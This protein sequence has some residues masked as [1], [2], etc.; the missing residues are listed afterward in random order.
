MTDLATK[1]QEGPGSRELD[2]AFGAVF[3]WRYHEERLVS[4]CWWGLED[5]DGTPVFGGWKPGNWSP[6]Q[7]ESDML[8]LARAVPGIIYITVHELISMTSIVTL[9]CGLFID[10]STWVTHEGIA[11]EA[12]CAGCIA[13]LRAKEAEK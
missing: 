12:T 9:S 8:T 10:Q 13:I 4:D 5:A 6:T 11:R 2:I 7:S 3:G 1:L